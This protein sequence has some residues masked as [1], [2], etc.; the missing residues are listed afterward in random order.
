[1]NDL[2]D[3]S[4]DSINSPEKA[5]FTKRNQTLITLCVI[6]AYCVAL[7]CAYL[8]NLY[9]VGI[10]LLPLGA[11]VLYSVRL[12]GFRLKDVLVMK[13]ALIAGISAFLAVLM[14]LASHSGVISLSEPHFSSVTFTTLLIAYFIFLKVFINT[15]L[16]DVRDMHGDRLADIVTIPVL[17]GKTKTRSMLLALNSTFILWI[18]FA[19][20]EGL[21]FTYILVLGASVVYGYWYI[22]HICR[23][24]EVKRSFFHLTVDG[25]WIYVA[26]VLALLAV[27]PVSLPIGWL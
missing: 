19:A 27:T 26:V 17:L 14:P 25:E 1:M 15:V 21:S 7:L 23:D 11:G 4:E 16:F 12:F 22:L 24:K 20:F 5:S 3:L 18:L 2:T 8:C 13:N 6:G 10:V 9:E